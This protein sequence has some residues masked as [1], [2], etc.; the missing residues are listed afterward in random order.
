LKHLL[1]S[2]QSF[3][4][5]T[6]SDTRL[7]PHH[8]V[9]KGFSFTQN[10]DLHFGAMVDSELQFKPSA[11]HKLAGG[12]FDLSSLN[13]PNQSTITRDGGPDASANQT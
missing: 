8:F 4:K 7:T 1:K 12:E 10:K 11:H 9:R 6:T 5:E 13:H 2:K 3:K